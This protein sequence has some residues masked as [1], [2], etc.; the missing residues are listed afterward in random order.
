MKILETAHQRKA[1]V[2]TAV[3]LMLLLFG[4]FN[5]GIKYLDPPIEYGVA[6]NLGS[7]D[8]GSG[9]PV[10]EMEL[11]AASQAVSEENES[12]DFDQNTEDQPEEEVE[13]EITEQT[14]PLNE[15]SQEI[16]EDI[17][18]DDTAKDAPSI[19]KSTKEKEVVKDTSEDTSEDKSEE[20]IKA[21]VKEKPKKTPKK[22]PKPSK[23]TTDA[24]N[25]LLNGTAN[26]GAKTGEGDDTE[27]GIKG[28]KNGDS[29]ASKYYGNSKSGTGGNY[30]LAGRK[31]LSK[32]IK[33][34]DCQEE[35][36]IVVSIEVNKNGIV[37]KAQTGGLKGSTSSAPCLEKAAKQAALKTIWN[38][39]NDAP[40]KQRGTIIYKFSLSE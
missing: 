28:N 4:V 23:Q 21:K 3:I 25:S 26:T 9:E 27:S 24:L 37:T 1:A 29:K 33:K 30:N 17:I 40:Q 34:P 36:T 19:A 13:E 38:A 11:A 7:S 8:V 39:A 32:P 12:Q 22:K 2:I 18:T 6:I 15:S 20:K 31:A 35:G 16:Q 10:E 5:F 14:P